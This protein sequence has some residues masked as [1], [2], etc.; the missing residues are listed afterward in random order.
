[1]PATGFED[2]LLL[3]T[4]REQVEADLATAGQRFQ[5]AVAESGLQTKW[6]AIPSAPDRVMALHARGADIIVASRPAD[7]FGS[8]CASAGVAVVATVAAAGVGGKARA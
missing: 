1:M 8:S 5:D 6:L 2:G 3:Q 7:G 4:L